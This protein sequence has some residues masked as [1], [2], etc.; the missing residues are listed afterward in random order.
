MHWL[1]L[2]HHL[3][4][5]ADL[6]MDERSV[7]FCIVYLNGDYWGIYGIREKID[8]HYIEDN[9]GY[10]DSEVDLLNSWNTLAGSDAHFVQAYDQIMMMDVDDFGYYD[11]VNS[12]FDLDNYKDYFIIQTYIQ[13]SDWMG[14]WW[15]L[16]NTKLWRPQTEDGRWRY[17]VY[18]TD[19]AFGY[20]GSWANDNYINWARYADNAHANIF[21]DLLNNAQFRCEFINRYADLIN[22]IFQS[23]NMI[24][25]ASDVQNELSLF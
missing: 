10:D 7:E 11:F 6:R 17:V 24:N 21:N 5:L 1:L 20:F 4:Q 22:T 2:V 14:I 16:N 15:G 9:F 23:S 8:E 13:N 19:A 12:K 25:L 18:D 3:S